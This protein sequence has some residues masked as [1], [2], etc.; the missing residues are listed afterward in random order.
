MNNRVLQNLNQFKRAHMRARRRGWGEW[1]GR[2]ALCRGR[3]ELAQGDGPNAG[4]LDEVLT[5][6]R[7]AM[8]GWTLFSSSGHFNNDI[9]EILAEY[10]CLVKDDIYACLIFA[11]ETL[12]D[13]SFVLVPTEAV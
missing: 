8:M 1:P 10:P 7:G 3:L 13:A 12:Q 9:N 4:K 6:G 2:Q 11:S 5:A